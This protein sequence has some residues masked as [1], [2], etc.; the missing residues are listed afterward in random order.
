MYNIIYLCNANIEGLNA[1]STLSI[2]AKNQFLGEALFLRDFCYFYLIN[3][4]GDVPYITTASG[5][6]RTKTASRTPKAQ[7]YQAL[8]SDLEFCQKVLKSDYSM[9][10]GQRTRA[11][12]SAATALLARVYLYAGNHWQDAMTQ[13]TQVIS[14]T[15]NI[16]LINNL[17]QVFLLSSTE[18]ILQW[19]LNPNYSQTANVTPE[20]YAILPNN[21][22]N[23]NP[24]NYFCSQQ[25]VSSFEPNDKRFL[26]W[27]DSSIYS[28]VKY[29]Y[30]YKYKVG[31]ANF[32]ST[33]PA[34]E[35]YIVFRLAEQYLI[36]AEAEAQLN[37]LSHAIA[38]LNVI[39]S[40]AGLPN[41]SLTL[42]QT[43][44]L[45]AVAQERRIELFAEWGH[46][47]LDLK[48]TGQVDPVMTIVTPLKSAGST[49]NSYQQLYPIPASELQTDP[50]L[51]QNP[52]Y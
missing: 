31:S 17:N 40:R 4:Y 49:W 46:R 27:V 36:R 14:N 25:L 15:A 44:V 51:T 22:I 16:S 42:N 6:D 8:I 9:S 10:A 28:G 1:S 41:L 39:R 12:Q 50:N 26:A 18:A 37:D 33:A 11:N 43:Q 35:Y 32:S 21:P 19:Q 2:S 45:A 3:L 29:Y 5:W 48:R 13:S 34:T 30:P 24:P 38:D 23:A 52:G 47:W 20:G 7:I